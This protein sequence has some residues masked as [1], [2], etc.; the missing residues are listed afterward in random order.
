MGRYALDGF[1]DLIETI[2]NVKDNS[3]MDK[4]QYIRILLTKYD[5]RNKTSNE[6]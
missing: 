5:S 6:W 2:D 4:N 1:S 3:E